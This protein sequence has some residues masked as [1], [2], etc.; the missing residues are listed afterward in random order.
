VSPHKVV[1]EYV[2]SSPGITVA[3]RCVIS[4]H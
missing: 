4:A 1:V 2:K 3:D